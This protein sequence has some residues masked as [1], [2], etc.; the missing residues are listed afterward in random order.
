M[1]VPAFQNFKRPTN[2]SLAR[3][4]GFLVIELAK[5]QYTGLFV[6]WQT[7]ILSRRRADARIYL[8]TVSMP[9]RPRVRQFAFISRLLSPLVCLRSKTMGSIALSREKL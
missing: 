1:I 9:A 4:A 7:G 5:I 2:C 8:D 6:P 3:V